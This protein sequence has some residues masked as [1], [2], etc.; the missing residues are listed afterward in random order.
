MHVAYHKTHKARSSTSFLKS[1]SS[2]PSLVY[3]PS[4]PSYRLLALIA[5]LLRLFRCSLC[6][7]CVRLSSPLPYA[8]SISPH[9]SHLLCVSLGPPSSHH[10]LFHICMSIRT[11]VGRRE[12]LLVPSFPLALS[13]SP[14][15]S[16]SLCHHHRPS[17]LAICSP[18]SAVFY[19]SRP[20][21]LYSSF[22]HAT[23]AFAVRGLP[24][25]S[26]SAH[27][28]YDNDRGS[29]SPPC[30]THPK[31]CIPIPGSDSRLR[32]AKGKETKEGG[33]EAYGGCC[34]CWTLLCLISS[35]H[36]HFPFCFLPPFLFRTYYHHH[37]HPHHHHHCP[38]LPIYSSAYLPSHITPLTI[39]ILTQYRPPVSTGTVPYTYIFHPSTNQPKGPGGQVPASRAHRCIVILF[40]QIF[41]LLSL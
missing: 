32:T 29:Y 7:L 2:S 15:S 10:L 21:V 6:V 41:L 3:S 18:F 22:R 33:A 25:S 20:R 30:G 19:L 37:P 26:S 11:V 38:H 13:P 34:S 17:P 14:P 5:Q 39:D 8:T 24:T 16:A 9:H 1:R 27:S 12:D 23:L 35:H 40:V 28:S 4:A 31:P 36:P